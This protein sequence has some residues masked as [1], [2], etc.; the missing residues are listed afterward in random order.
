MALSTFDFLLNL[1]NVFTSYN[2]KAFFN[3]V[4][5]GGFG[6]AHTFKDGDKTAINNVMGKAGLELNFRLGDRWNLFLDGNMLLLPENF[7]YR[8]GGDIVQDFV[9]NYTIGLTYRFNFRHF[10]KAPFHDN[11][12]IDELNREINELRNRP[13]VIC[14]PVVVCPEPEI[15]KEVVELTPVFFTLDSYIVRDN[16][17][18]SIANAAK[19]LIN[20]PGSKLEIAAYADRNTGNPKYNMKLSENRVNAVAKVMIEKFGIAG[21]RLQLRFYGDTVQPFDENDWNRVA[22]F[23]VP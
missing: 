13:E 5:Y 23:I 1:K 3:P 2:P 15:E 12:Q 9:G 8:V 11:S 19:Y 6:Y 21:D 22:I 7:D 18:L 14:P 16:Q 4:L 17:L 20:N 10:I